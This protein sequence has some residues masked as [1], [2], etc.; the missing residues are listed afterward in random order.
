LL[1]AAALT[2]SYTCFHPY[3]DGNKRTALMATSFFLDLNA[4]SFSIPDNAPEFARELAMRT[5]DTMSHDPTVEIS[6]VS[7]W[8]KENTRRAFMNRFS[9]AR[10][11]KKALARGLSG[12]IYI[13]DELMSPPQ[14]LIWAIEKA[15]EF[16]ILSH[17]ERVPAFSASVTTST[18]HLDLT[19]EKEPKE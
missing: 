12:D 17:L 2:Y 3:A 6:R 18:I 1:K 19:M 8:L 15:R 10:R 9:Y 14:R 4:C 11:T 13:D 16:G 7:H 5:I